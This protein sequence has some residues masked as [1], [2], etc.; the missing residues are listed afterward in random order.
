[1]KEKTRRGRVLWI[2][3]AAVLISLGATWIIKNKGPEGPTTATPDGSISGR[4][5]HD[6]CAQSAED[7]LDPASSPP[8]C[9][10]SGEGFLANGIYEPGEPGIPGIRV[11]L[12]KGACP[13]SGLEAD[14]TAGNGSFRFEDLEPGAYCVSVDQMNSPGLTALTP[15]AWTS[16]LGGD[17]GGVGYITL[18][19]AYG[20][21]NADVNF[22]WGDLLVQP[23]PTAVP[24]SP[25]PTPAPM[26]TNSATFVRDVTISDGTR[27]E[28]GRTFTKTW[29]L[30]NS[31]TCTWTP[32]YALVF[33]DGDRM[34]AAGSTALLG[35][36][37]PGSTVDL[38]AVLQAPVDDGLYSGYWMLRNQEGGRFGLGQGANKPFRVQIRVGPP[39]PPVISDW[40]GEYYANRKLEGD[41]YLVRN[42]EEIDFNWGRGAPME[43]FPS[44]DFSV[45]WTQSLKFDS[46]LYRL[47]I[48][49]DDG[50]RLWVD[51]RMVIDEWQDGSARERTIDLAMAKGSH[52]LQLDY[53]ERGGAAR[54]SLWW[55]KVKGPKSGWVGKYW[56]NRK[57]NSSWALVR[58]DSE[59]DFDWGDEAPALGIPR[60]DFSAQW[61]K[62]MEFA[63][64]T[65]R[66]H[67]QADDGLRVYLD[68]VL[69]LDEWHD[70][71]GTEV[72][73][74]EVELNGV[75][76]LEVE[77]YERKGDAKI[78][79]WWEK[80]GEMNSPPIAVEDA[81][82][83][84]ED[85][86]LTAA[87][88]GVLGND[89]DADGDG[90]TAVLESGPKSGTLVL[91][92]DGSFEYV[93]APNFHGMD[94]F[95]YRA[96][97]GDLASSPATV[98]ITVRSVNDE[99]VAMDD[100]Y[101]TDED[102]PL[103]I[104]AP[105]VLAND[106]DEEGDPL[107]AVLESGVSHGSLILNEDG[108]FTYTPEAGFTGIDSFTY[109]ASDG[110][111][112]SNLATVTLAVGNVSI[113]PAAE[114]LSVHP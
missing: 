23:R 48:L 14:M 8:G 101:K 105:G 49:G 50:I 25:S 91:D 108:S 56:F 22:G 6:L 103:Q 65:Y 113:G 5:W 3:L 86:V 70:S 79:C 52:D 29:R 27:I 71:G 80:V 74:A 69:L 18:A 13:S 82:L 110:D 17:S 51:D 67:A 31:G 95:S 99:P 59:I 73:T 81:Y 84:D 53:Y 68:D 78:T 30:T 72:Y 12:G 77:Y 109:W 19:L 64:G 57:L 10:P 106:S 100:F 38:T 96:S 98:T 58:S 20:E 15:G 114:D 7:S 43:G 42:D 36:V 34:G 9:V 61:T 47:H 87:A 97:D 94:S 112:G 62:R 90:L 66:L 32:E 46:A 39:P 24:P 1:M 26:C 2:L 35:N 89:E 63:P 28:A 75:H 111:L 11:S 107:E 54:V 60:N 33:V 93:P 92:E 16:P 21:A 102:Q 88:P 4:V 104:A 55:E 45:R 76:S 40:R 85:V 44:D 37:P 83:V 41:P